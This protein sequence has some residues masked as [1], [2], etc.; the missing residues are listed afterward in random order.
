M[1][2]LLQAIEAGYDYKTA[3]LLVLGDNDEA[4]L[5]LQREA[6][7]AGDLAQE[8]LCRNALREPYD[9]GPVTGSARMACARALLDHA[10]PEH[11]PE[12]YAAMRPIDRENHHIHLMRFPET[13][14]TGNDLTRAFF[15]AERARRVGAAR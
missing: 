4:I 12:A 9:Q 1:T 5:G 2:T 14:Q 8:V 10:I 13:R 15:A 7:E 6:A 11:D 3:V